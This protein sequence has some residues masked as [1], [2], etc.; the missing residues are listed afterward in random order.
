MHKMSI[1]SLAPMLQLQIDNNQHWRTPIPSTT[2]PQR[3][4]PLLLLLRHHHLCLNPRAPPLLLLQTL[5][6]TTGFP[7]TPKQQT[8]RNGKWTIRNHGPIPSSHP[9]PTGLH[10]RCDHCEHPGRRLPYPLFISKNMCLRH[11]HKI[12][13]RNSRSKAGVILIRNRPRKPNRRRLRRPSRSDR[14]S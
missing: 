1:L 5:G 8:L 13:L 11:P 6:G 2:T 14:F 4:R 9:W 12:T 10:Q 7:L 3:Y